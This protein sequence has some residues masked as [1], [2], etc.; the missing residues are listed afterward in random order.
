MRSSKDMLDVITIGDSLLD[1]FLGIEEATVTCQLNKEA[2]LL[3]LEYAEKIPLTSVVKV[4]GAGNSSNAAV[5]ATFL[6]LSSA[7]VSVLGKDDVGGEILLHW[8]KL[9]VDTRFVQLDK[10]HDT[11]YAT[12]LNFKGERTQLIYFHPRNYRLPKLVSTRWMYY[13]AIGSKHEMLEK[14]MLAFLNKQPETKLVFNPGTTHLRR[15]L[16]ALLPVIAASEVFCVNKQEAERLLEDGERPVHNLLMK[17][18]KLGPEIVVITD[19]PKG[20][21]ATD[22]RSIWH[23]PIFPGPVVERT[24]AGDSYTTAFM[25]ALHHGKGIADAMRWGTANSWSV[26]QFVGPQA[27]LLSKTK[28]ASTLKKFASFKPTMIPAM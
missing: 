5:G 19:G 7:I 16:K 9:G 13:S 11:N 6:G 25:C 10:T 20:S 22:G 24:G 12:I 27:G 21:Y 17:M 15:G 2:C 8:N 14:Q 18:H 23:M 26:V 1:V 3:C 4:P 28:I